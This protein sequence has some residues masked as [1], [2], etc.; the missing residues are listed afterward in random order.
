M[1]P[2]HVCEHIA[3]VLGF[4]YV[5]HLFIINHAVDFFFSRNRVVGKPTGCADGTDGGRF[6]KVRGSVPR[7]PYPE[8]QWAVWR[9]I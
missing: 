2:L 8:N 4:A 7:A 5:A 9:T 3:Y 6:L 1:L